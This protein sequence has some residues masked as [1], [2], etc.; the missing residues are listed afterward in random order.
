MFKSSKNQELL[1][2]ISELESQNQ[3]LTQE[4]QE[5]SKA[6]AT[7][8][9]KPPVNDASLK[10]KEELSL[11]LIDGLRDSMTFLQQGIDENVDMLTEI[12]TYNEES[13]KVAEELTEN[14]NSVSKSTET[15][16]D[17]T[18]G[19][20]DNAQ[21]L[22]QSVDEISLVINLIKDISDQTNLLALNAAIEAARAGEHGRGFAVVADEVRK[23]AERTQK[24]TQEVEINI[25]AL[26][27]NSTS[28]FEDSERFETVATNTAEFLDKFKENLHDMLENSQKIKNANEN[29]SNE[30]R[31]N[32]GKIDHVYLKATGYY[33]AISHGNDKLDDHTSCRFGSWYG[34]DAQALVGHDTSNFNEVAR[35]HKVVHDNLI[36]GVNEFNADQFS[37]SLESFKMV[38]HSSKSAFETLMNMMRQVRK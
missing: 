30:I 27:Q 22:T 18:T 5:L 26:K 36:V 13:S 7:A 33:N 35:Q 17:M 14:T 6:L 9:E 38:E 19:L 25:G 3:T 20:R 34:S 15:I 32:L 4:N 31:V 1:N 16:M 23:L 21:H 28:M 24:A 10:T 11:V 29:V 37:K 2:R 12:N 8:Q